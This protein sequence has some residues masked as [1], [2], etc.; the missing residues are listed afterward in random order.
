M[1]AG[2][3]LRNKNGT[4]YTRYQCSKYRGL[5]DRCDNKTSI[6]A[7][8]VDDAVWQRALEIIHNT[9]EVDKRLA[10]LKSEDPT[11]DRRKHISN[12]LAKVKK[13]QAVFREQLAKL[14]MEEEI[15]RGTMDFLKGQLKQLADQEEEWKHEIVNEEDTHNKWKRVQEKLIELHKTCTD[16]RDKLSDPNYE[17]SYDTKRELIEYFGITAKVWKFGNSPRF[18]IECNPPDIVSHIS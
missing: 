8:I 4:V 5:I 13:T 11:L 10:R 14:M 1:C 18:E 6:P 16:M 17:L 3:S 9:S 15:D 7:R 12:Q 2:R